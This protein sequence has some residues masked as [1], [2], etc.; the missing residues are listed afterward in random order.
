M[1]F[2][3]TGLVNQYTEKLTF[4]KDLFAKAGIQYGVTNKKQPK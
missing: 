3:F 1:F 2:A 4:L